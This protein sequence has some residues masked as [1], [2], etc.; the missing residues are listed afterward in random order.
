MFSTVV[1]IY[2]IVFVNK[3]FQKAYTQDVFI[4]VRVNRVDEKATKILNQNLKNAHKVWR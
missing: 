3:G 1:N 2:I 4:M